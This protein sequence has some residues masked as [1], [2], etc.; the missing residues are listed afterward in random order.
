[1]APPCCPTTSMSSAPPTPTTRCGRPSEKSSPP[2]AAA[3]PSNASPS[4]TP[5]PTRTRAWP[6]NCSM[7][8]VSRATAGPRWPS[9]SG[10]R[11]ARCLACS[12]FPTA[13]SG[14]TTCSPSSPAHPCAALAALGYPPRPGSASHARP[15]WSP[16][17]A[18][19]TS[20]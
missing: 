7:P 8:P 10:S 13:A 20:A 14:A 16:G 18:N 1:M 6:A 4:A 3:C 17:R 2:R 5:V 11:L 19:G 15:V 9:G 12:P